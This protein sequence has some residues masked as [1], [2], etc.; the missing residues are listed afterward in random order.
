MFFGPQKA[1]WA[2]DAVELLLAEAALP[3]SYRRI[4]PGI[5]VEP[6]TRDNPHLRPINVMA[7]GQ[8][9]QRTRRRLW[10]CPVCYALHHLGLLRGADLNRH[11][12]VQIT[13]N[14][15]PAERT[16]G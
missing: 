16:D 10:N 11:Y 6:I 4:P 14:L 7:Y 13:H 8:Q 15:R 12:R 9:K 2:R 5:G 1:G 3:L